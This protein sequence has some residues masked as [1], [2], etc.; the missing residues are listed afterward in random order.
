L[1]YKY[2]NFRP[3]SKITLFKQNG[4]TDYHHS[5]VGLVETGEALSLPETRYIGIL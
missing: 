2:V 4:D 1:S 3:D 5:M